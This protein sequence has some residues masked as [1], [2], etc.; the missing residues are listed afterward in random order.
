MKLTADLLGISAAV[1]IAKS[2][3]YQLK[4][5]RTPCADLWAS[6]KEIPPNE[7]LKNAGLPTALASNDSHLRQIRC[8]VKLHL[9]QWHSTLNFPRDFEVC[10]VYCQSIPGCSLKCT[11]KPAQVEQVS[12]MK[13]F[14]LRKDILD[15]VYSWNQA[16][17]KCPTPVCH[18]SLYP[19]Q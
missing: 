10:S 8:K 1:H 14:Y 13:L 7:C 19:T 12:H 3:A 2:C 15:P 6:R 11:G 5:E 18:V 17:A 16:I 9:L 4:K